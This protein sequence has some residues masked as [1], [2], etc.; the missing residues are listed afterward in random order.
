MASGSR[1]GPQI[2]WKAEE[3]DFI[4]ETDLK[5]KRV[6]PELCR[7]RGV[8]MDSEPDGKVPHSTGLHR[9]RGHSETSQT[10]KCRAHVDRV[11][12]ALYSCINVYN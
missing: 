7:P 1:A 3:R 8:P 9:A 11:R 12:T 4:K 10:V 6:F 2:I 5:G